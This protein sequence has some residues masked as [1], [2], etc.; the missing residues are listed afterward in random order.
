LIPENRETR[1]P[2]RLWG[3]GVGDLTDAAY[4]F[5]SK[6]AKMAQPIEFRLNGKPVTLNVDGSRP[7]LW[8]LRSD[9]SLTGTKFGCGEG[10]CGACTILIDGE[11]DR[12]CL[13]TVGD[14]EGRSLTT[15]EGL[16]AGDDLHPLQEAFVEQ[17]ALQCGYCTPGM[18]LTA[19]G[20]LSDNEN[21]TR[22]EIIAHMNENYCR[23]G[24]HKRIVE[25]IESAATTMKK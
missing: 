15:I 2:Q 21:P 9:L 4:N 20:L 22:S 23:C 7:L 12:S 24:A 1:N 17:G 3:T 18:I 5:I 13:L 16:A 10:Y 8:A 14:V 11:P 6:P 25:A 19:V